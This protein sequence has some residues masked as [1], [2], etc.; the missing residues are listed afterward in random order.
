MPDADADEQ[1]TGVRTFDVVSTPHENRLPL[2]TGLNNFNP[3]IS[4]SSSWVRSNIY[5]IFASA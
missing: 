1:T 4:T 3:V 2:I 5:Q